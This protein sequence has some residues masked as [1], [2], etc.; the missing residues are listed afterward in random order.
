VDIL[1]T[2]CL[3]ALSV[4]SSTA[5]D[6]SRE[7]KAGQAA[8]DVAASWRIAEVPASFPVRFSLLTHGNRQYV[9]YY[10]AQRRMTVAGRRLDSDEWHYEVL[11]SSVGWDSHNYITMAVDSAGYLHLSGN[12]HGVPLIYFRTEQPGDIA[13][14][15]KIDAMVGRDEQRCTYPVF[16]DGPDDALIFHYRDGGSGRGNQI[17]NIYDVATRTWRRLIDE[18]LIDGRGE[19]NA[20]LS[21]PSLG[22]DGWFHLA[23]VWRDTPDCETNHTPSYARSRDLLAWETIDGRPIEL[24]ITCQTPGTLIDPVPAFAGLINGSLHI[25]FDSAGQPLASYHKFDADGNTQVYVARFEDGAWVPRQVSRWNYRWAF[26][27]R[28]AIPFE[29][30]LGAFGPHGEGRLAL[31]FEHVKYGQGL[32]VVDE[33]PLTPLGTEPQPVRYPPALTA[34]KS[35]FEGMRVHWGEDLRDGGDPAVRYVLRWETLSAH[36]DRPREGLLPEPGPLVLYKLSARP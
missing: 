3:C 32:L 23:W 22:P 12:M 33:R 14:F 13:T 25:G 21:G 9:A 28:G 10:D 5:T 17:F 7:D 15:R 30:R 24:P 1:M 20:Y 36:R 2:M 34:P 11:P 29:I 4:V 18:P 35:D 19:M 6:S 27:G 8:P 26:E 16:M 31:P